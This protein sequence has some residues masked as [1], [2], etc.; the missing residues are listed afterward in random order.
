MAVFDPSF[1]FTVIVAVPAALAVT[2][3]E[4]D[5][6]ATEVLF[7]DHV[8][9]LFVASE[10]STVA[11]RVSESPSVI[12]REVLFKETEV[13]GLLTVTA[14][15]AVFDPSFVFTVIVA[16]PAAFAVTKPSE[17]TKATEVLLDDQVTDLSV[18]SEGSTVAVRVSVS[19][20]V[21]E[22]EVLSRLIPVTLIVLLT[23]VTKHFAECTPSS[24]RAVIVAIPTDLAVKSP[25]S[26][27]W[28]TSE[29]LEVHNT[30][31]SDVFVG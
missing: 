4:E 31:L 16:V 26:E 21:I 5:T 13:T 25:A 8:T 12:V 20:S 30:S 17:E 23:T 24:E 6:V 1:V 14:H 27:T 9:D 29:L 7:E 15:D 3:P 19:P 11:I 22:R 2:I 18:A 10:G 28:A